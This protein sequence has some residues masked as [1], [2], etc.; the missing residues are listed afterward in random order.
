MKKIKNKFLYFILFLIFAIILVVLY[1]LFFKQNIDRNSYVELISG[2][3]FLN[4]VNLVA[5]EKEILKE[6]DEIK[7]GSGESM[8]IIEW[9]DWSI[10]RL[11]ENTHLKVDENYFSDDW[12]IVKVI[13]KIFSG[14]TWSNVLSYIPWDSHFK[15]VFDDTEV[16]VRWTIYIIDLDKNYLYVENHRVVLTEKDGKIIEVKEK[17]PISTKT[18]DF[19][20]LSD[21]ILKLKDK[22]FFRENK[23]LDKKLYLVLKQNLQDQLKNLEKLKSLD[24]KKLWEKELQKA[25]REVLS[26]YQ[27]LNFISTA[28]WEELFGLKIDIKQKLMDLSSPLEKANLAQSFFYDFKDSVKNKNFYSF[29]K[30][31]EVLLQN[32][33]YFDFSEFLVLLWSINITDKL[34]ELIKEDLEKLKDSFDLWK[35][36]WEKALKWAVDLDKKLRE[37]ILDIKKTTEEKVEDWF[38]KV[39]KSKETLDRELQNQAR[40]WINSIENF[41]EEKIWET[42]NRWN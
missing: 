29:D 14:K 31:T 17:E 6:N 41:L 25:Y 5:W 28:D 36:L 15:Q 13:F 1:M 4:N 26:N 7:A 24:Y 23:D 37:W 40:D 16:A 21:F 42:L 27:K 20:S 32:K 22:V 33:K 19:I 8:V 30:I 12:N 2:S 38:K 9:W 18:F 39:I 34:N 11:G 3:W 35:E 10:T